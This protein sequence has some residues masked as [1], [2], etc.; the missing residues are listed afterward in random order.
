[1]AKKTE[2]TIDHKSLAEQFNQQYPGLGWDEG[3]VAMYLESFD[4]GLGES[5]EDHLECLA[6]HQVLVSSLITEEETNV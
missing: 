6:D 1:M 4:E 2:S 3:I 5:V